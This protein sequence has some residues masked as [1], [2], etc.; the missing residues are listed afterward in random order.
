MPSGTGKT[1]S[2]LSLIVAYQKV[3]LALCMCV[4]S[5]RYLLEL[6][7]TVASHQPMP[8]E[9]IN[10]LDSLFLGLSLSLSQAF[11]LEVSKLIYC[12]RTVPEIEKVSQFIGHTGLMPET[13]IYPL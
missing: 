8:H 10:V 9:L 7:S 4:T 2:L 11:P 5:F 12:S 3:S 6:W 13:T 1:I